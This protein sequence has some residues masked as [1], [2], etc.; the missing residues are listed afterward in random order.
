M[1]APGRRQ[2]V[3]H[4]VHLPEVLLDQLDRLLLD[5][6]IDVATDLDAEA[7]DHG[8]QP[9]GEIRVAEE[10]H[11]SLVARQRVVGV[12]LLEIVVALDED[13]PRRVEEL[14]FGV[15]VDGPEDDLL[16]AADAPGEVLRLA[17][18][19]R[20]HA[21]SSANHAVRSFVVAAGSSDAAATAA[22]AAIHGSP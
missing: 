3:D 19:R 6:A 18:V 16:V 2:G 21:A 20:R 22:S 10:L 8:T 12:V 11:R 9:T 14:R 1:L 7:E 17:A 13:G 5:F 4:Q 15:E